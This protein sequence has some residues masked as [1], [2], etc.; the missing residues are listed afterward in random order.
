MRLTGVVEELPIRFCVLLNTFILS[1][2]RVGRTSL[3]AARFT[4]SSAVACVPL[5]LHSST[6]AVSFCSSVCTVFLFLELLHDN[7]VRQIPTFYTPA[8]YIAHVV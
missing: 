5:G 2:F 8:I 4:Q 7:L 6:D 1:H 3:W